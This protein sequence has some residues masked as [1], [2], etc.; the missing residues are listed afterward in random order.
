MILSLDSAVSSL[1]EC[2][3]TGV[4]SR[5]R[6]AVDSGHL[7]RSICNGARAC[8]LARL[9]DAITGPPRCRRAIPL[10]ECPVASTVCKDIQRIVRLHCL[11]RHSVRTRVSNARL[12]RARAASNA[13]SLVIIFIS[14]KRRIDR[15]LERVGKPITACL[16]SLLTANFH[17]L[18]A[19]AAVKLIDLVAILGKPWHCSCCGGTSGESGGNQS[20]PGLARRSRAST[21][22]SSS[23]HMSFLC[24]CG[25]CASA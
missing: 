5:P 3:A 6:G 23:V 18:V 14:S 8:G 15:M 2:H 7:Q 16:G 11:P 22:R 21:G 9:P 10:G 20:A 25:A 4:A 17:N 12:E 19:K 13:P 24:A 1:E